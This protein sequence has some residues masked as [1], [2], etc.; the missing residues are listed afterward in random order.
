LRERVGGTAGAGIQFK[1]GNQLVRVDAR[2]TLGFTDINNSGDSRSI[3]NRAF[4]ATIG[5]GF[6]LGR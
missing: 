4:A 2:Y 3:K 6:P 5:L 1:A